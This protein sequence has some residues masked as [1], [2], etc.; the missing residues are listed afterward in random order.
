MALRTAIGYLKQG[1]WK[2]AHE[3]VQSDESTFGC[4]AH[5]IVHML[6]GDVANARYWY[7]RAHRSY[8][9]SPD[10]SAEVAALAQALNDS[11]TEDAR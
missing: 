10:A 11:N 6:E 8:P 4:W 2:Q 3:I 1:D 9:E 5:G 7:R